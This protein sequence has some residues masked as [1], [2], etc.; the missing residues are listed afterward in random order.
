VSVS[1]GDGLNP[2]CV[3][4]ATIPTLTPMVIVKDWPPK[5]LLRALENS[6]KAST[7]VV[8]DMRLIVSMFGEAVELSVSLLED[9]NTPESLSAH[10][11]SL[12]RVVLAVEGM[13]A[14]HS[15]QDPLYPMLIEEIK[16]LKEKTI[17]AVELLGRS[18]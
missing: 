4:F 16:L 3:S 18:E 5:S 11:H 2:T 7:E 1:N 6:P 8:E 9:G 15:V 13:V 17:K 12:D 14:R 10:L